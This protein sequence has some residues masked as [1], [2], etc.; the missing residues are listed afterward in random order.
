MKDRTLLSWNIEGLA[1]QL[2][3]AAEIMDAYKPELAFFQETLAHKLEEPAIANKLGPARHFSLNANDQYETTFGDRL[4]VNKKNAIHGTG[5]IV[6]IDHAG[7][8]F[9]VHDSVT[10]RIQ[11]MRLNDVNYLNL[12]LPTKDESQ[13]G[14]EKLIEALADLDNILEPIAGE[15]IVMA[16][17]L[18]VGKNHGPWRKEQFKNLFNKHSLTLYSPPVPTN[19]PRGKGA[20]Q[21][22]DHMVCSSHI[23]EVKCEVL[24]W[25]KIPLNVS[26]HTP[27]IWRFKVEETLTPEAPEVPSIKG[28][29]IPR[30]DW[31]HKVDYELY[32][33]IEPIYV[34][35]AMHLISDFPAPWRARVVE[36]MLAK[37]AA[38]A[39]MILP[40]QSERSSRARKWYSDQIRNLTRS[41]QRL[42]R[43]FAGDFYFLSII[44]LK[45]MFPHDDK[46]KE[47]AVLEARLTTIKMELNKELRL[48]MSEEAERDSEDL[49]I[50]MRNGDSSA[51]HTNSRVNQVIVN[52]CPKI[53]NHEGKTHV[54]EGVLACFM[55]AAKK[56]SGDIVN[57][58]GNVPTDAYVLKKEIVMMVENCCLTD[59]TYFVELTKENYDKVLSLLPSNKAPD[60]YGAMSEHFKYAGQETNEC[61]RQIFN[62]ILQ[63]IR[64]FSD[65]FIS[66]SVGRYIH[67]GKGR[68]PRLVRS[69]RRIQVGTLCQKFI[70]RLVEYQCTQVV[71]NHAVVN[72]WGFSAGIS[73]LQCPVVRECLTKLAIEKKTPL[74]CIAADVQSAFSR[75]DRFC[76]LYENFSQGEFGK[77]FLFSKQ[78]A[79]NTDV[80]LTCNNQMSSRFSEEQGAPQGS[81]RSSGSWK[82]YS[83]PLYKSISNSDIGVKAYGIDFG[84]M[85][86][87]DD[88]LA[89][90][91]SR[92]RFKLM[93]TLYMSYAHDYRVTYEFSK[94][95]LNLWGVKNP[96]KETEGLE[97]GGYKHTISKESVHVGLVICQDQSSS[98]TVNINRRLAKTNA[99]T[100]QIMNK[101]WS[102]RR[103]IHLTIHRELIK[104]ITK[105]MLLSGLQAVTI[106]DNDLK[107]L[108]RYQDKMV[109]KTANVRKSASV[110]LLEMI[111]QVTPLIADYHR[112]VISLLY[113]IWVTKGSCYDLMIKL[114]EDDTIKKNYWPHHASRILSLYDLPDAYSILK[115]QPVAKKAFKD[116]VKFKIEQHYADISNS[117]IFSSSLYR[118]VYHG[119]FTFTRKKLHPMVTAATTRREIIGLKLNILHI[120]MDYENNENRARI[121]VKK[122]KLCDICKDEGRDIIDSTE[123]NLFFCVCLRDDTC[124]D[125][126]R[127]EIITLI[128]QLKGINQRTVTQLIL[129]APTSAALLFINPTSAGLPK[130]FRLPSDHFDI[131][132]VFKKLQNY[133]IICHNLRRR[134]GDFKTLP[135][136]GSS[137]PH[138]NVRRS[139]HPPNSR[140]QQ[141]RLSHGKT[142]RLISE[143]FSTTDGLFK[144]KVGFT[145]GEALALERSFGSWTVLGTW[146]GGKIVSISGIRTNE[147]GLYDE[148]F[149]CGLLRNHIHE[150]VVKHLQIQTDD[151]GGILRKLAVVTLDAFDVEFSKVLSKLGLFCIA[152]DKEI[153]RNCSERMPVSLL[154]SRD[155]TPVK[156]VV[157]DQYS[158]M[159]KMSVFN[160]DRRFNE[161]KISPEDRKI[162]DQCGMDLGCSAPI[163]DL[164][165]WAMMWLAEN[166]RSIIKFTDEFSWCHESFGRLLLEFEYYRPGCAIIIAAKSGMKWP[167]QQVTQLTQKRAH[168]VNENWFQYRCY[169]NS[170]RLALYEAVDFNLKASEFSC[171]LYTTVSYDENV[172]PI[173]AMKNPDEEAKDATIARLRRIIAQLQM[174]K[175]QLV[176]DKDNARHLALHLTR[177]NT[178]LLGKLE[179]ELLDADTERK[180]GTRRKIRWENPQVTEAEAKQE[181]ENNNRAKVTKH[182]VAP[183]ERRTTFEQKDDLRL[184]LNAKRAAALSEAI[185]VPMPEEGCDITDDT[186]PD[187]SFYEP[188]DDLPSLRDER[189]KK[190]R[191]VVTSSSSS[192]GEPNDLRQRLNQIRRKAKKKCDNGE[193]CQIIDVID[194]NKPGM[195][196]ITLQ[197]TFSNKTQEEV[198]S[199]PHDESHA[200]VEQMDITDTQLTTDGDSMIGNGSLTT[201]EA[202]KSP[203]T[204]QLSPRSTL[205]E[206]IRKILDS[207]S[208]S[209]PSSD[210]RDRYKNFEEGKTNK[211]GVDSLYQLSLI[212]I[213][214]CR[215]AKIEVADDSIAIVQKK[216][217]KEVN[218]VE[219]DTAAP[220]N[221]DDSVE[222]IEAEP[223]KTVEPEPEKMTAEKSLLSDDSV[224]EI[225]QD[226][227]S[228][229]ILSHTKKVHHQEP[230]SPCTLELSTLRLSNPDDSIV[231]DSN[232]SD[233]LKVDEY[234]CN[235]NRPTEKIL[236]QLNETGNPHELSLEDKDL[237]RLLDGDSDTSLPHAST[238]TSSPRR[239]SDSSS[240]PGSM[241]SLVSVTP[242]RDSGNSTNDSDDSVNAI[243]VQLPNQDAVKK[244]FGNGYLLTLIKFLNH[245]ECRRTAP[246]NETRSTP[247]ALRCSPTLER[248]DLEKLQNCIISYL[249]LF[250]LSYMSFVFPSERAQYPLVIVNNLKM[251]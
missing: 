36:G 45:K 14:K 209:A 245:F 8:N 136:R 85:L 9:N 184:T 60:I 43:N 93:N 190:V 57:I 27:I 102:Q 165:G 48:V 72:Q 175:N 178:I 71:S 122:S 162:Y 113:N 130:K 246:V 61:M 62:E 231:S 65:C 189:I 16:G 199:S 128:A 132:F 243:A 139:I 30:P 241:P 1:K 145:R 51:F 171:P 227:P 156:V 208:S 232:L 149:R 248:M 73:F 101:C 163:Q 119:D 112:S 198:H 22:L 155:P 121:K 206:S 100:W 180:D 96:E 235:A 172:A 186:R 204:S 220:L 158:E 201:P 104:S 177:H 41:I 217:F 84:Q 42:R 63:D 212:T 222:V 6:D 215:S 44:E 109:R 19:Y 169:V 92:Q 161:Q 219:M 87:A 34:K 237:E 229:T 216:L 21:A 197:R 236:D 160:R 195:S 218:D 56:E 247:P 174:D 223:V 39:R 33:R 183:F 74:Y 135:K 5:I 46:V 114:L 37:A 203:M 15:P 32:N 77:I 88:S 140:G 187:E 151:V 55:S 47:I 116:F 76:Q 200:S 64:Q 152:P 103:T 40:D 133:L 196:G 131:K 115:S 146:W 86:I 49:L 202:F 238:P 70:Q 148:V 28:K 191:G 123:H 168:D 23:S 94:L 173:T 137:R 181:R 110:I 108:S 20:P 111:L 124:A 138:L 205:Q 214:S 2:H 150:G 54:G 193:E 29:K 53:L 185:P 213:V 97:F 147:I 228:L 4:E 79:S 12:Y 211:S 83:V 142:G 230:T 105:P 242:P 7:K 207:S 210:D 58:P 125:E 157:L 233:V 144:H 10:A 81:I 11:H 78:F 129:S 221:M 89:M 66:L 154:V 167:M 82:N 24:D 134:Y 224:Q 194:V 240:D 59:N 141:P 164:S 234:E 249:S 179:D 176:L 107:P 91:T 25:S 153:T 35:T 68:D 80:V 38:R 106:P 13:L 251:E 95:E 18:N 67:K 159:I 31:R 244:D 192:E 90:T 52:D 182:D 75:T 99:R 127:A 118:F 225:R 120:C 69:Y 50:S 250:I 26:T 98:V 143:Y 239:S 166:E 226:E 188:Q 126:A 3:T 117:R 17:D 170:H